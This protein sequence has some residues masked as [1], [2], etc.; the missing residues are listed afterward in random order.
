MEQS[1]PISLVI[2]YPE[3]QNR[4]T[5]LFRPL[6]L[7]P[8]AILLSLLIGGESQ[9]Q[10]DTGAPHLAAA[11]PLVILPTLLMIVIR[12]KYPRWWYD[13]NLQ[14]SNF[15]ARV[16]AYGLLLTDLYPA[17]EDEQA[18]HIQL[19]YPD[20]KALNRWLPLVK[21]FLA[22]PHYLVLLILDVLA[23]FVVLASWLAI[24]FTGR[25]PRGVFDFMAGLF[26]WHLRVAAYAFLLT[27]DQY[28]PFSLS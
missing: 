21:W 9:S 14:M 12:Q 24:L 10:S 26:Q 20:A 6:L 19:P 28:P 3:V 22:I 23:I 8:A 11:S 15:I 16:A 1:N 7:I 17:T 13:W 5:V 2:D 25:N 18:V 27:T 4:L